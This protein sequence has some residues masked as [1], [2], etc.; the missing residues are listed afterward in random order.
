M[1]VKVKR[2][3]EIMKGE[4]QGNCNKQKMMKRKIELVVDINEDIRERE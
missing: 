4:N 3:V 1:K 2:E